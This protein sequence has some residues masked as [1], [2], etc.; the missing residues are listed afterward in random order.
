MRLFAHLQLRPC[1]FVEHHR[2]SIFFLQIVAARGRIHL[3]FSR[4][5][6]SQCAFGVFFTRS[7]E[8]TQQ[9]TRPATAKGTATRIFVLSV[10]RGGE[11][12]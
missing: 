1:L 9:S 12:R 3:T 2:L 5:V 11:H 7:S 10:R 6:F 8:P 4:D